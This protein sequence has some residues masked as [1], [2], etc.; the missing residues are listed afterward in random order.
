[1]LLIR[2]CVDYPDG[3]CLRIS[4]SFWVAEINLASVFRSS[5]VKSSASFLFKKI[6]RMTM[7]N[8]SK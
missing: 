8:S 3:R 2:L 7:C 5:S 6:A 4:N 1:M